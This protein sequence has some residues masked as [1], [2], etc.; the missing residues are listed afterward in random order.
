MST[1]P[2]ADEV[3]A[4]ERKLRAWIFD[5]PDQLREMREETQDEYCPC[6]MSFDFTPESLSGLEE[7]L[8]AEY[9]TGGRVKLD[10]R[11]ARWAAYYLGEVLLSVAG[12]SWGWSRRP[13]KAAPGRQPVICP[14][15]ALDQSPIPLLKLLER[16]TARRTGRVFTDEVDRLRA[17]VAE[18]RRQDPS[19][20]PAVR[21]HP[22][23]QRQLDEVA[24][25]Q[26]ELDVW[27]AARAEA[28]DGWARETGRPESWDFTLDSLDALEGL[29]RSRYAGPE[30]VSAARTG[31]FVQ[32]A[33]WYIGEVMC[34]NARAAEWRYEARAEAPDDT[35]LP[36]FGPGDRSSVLDS[37]NVSQPS[38][39]EGGRLYP[40]GA[41]NTLFW[42][43]DELDEPMD[44]HLRDV[45]DGF[46]R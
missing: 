13:A 44:A 41:L 27:L 26:A 10:F 3:D 4:V 6:D 5:L 39:R 17:E 42:E 16:A 11:P 33:V 21:P 20:S 29:V 19:W 2:L 25:G 28:F 7:W 12:G 8:L 34:R 9:E 31:P 18:R 38:L 30:E 45:L 1:R 35:T 24:A 36:L 46:A 15:P 40:L 32:G 43:H 23:Q 14:D 37:P 22:V